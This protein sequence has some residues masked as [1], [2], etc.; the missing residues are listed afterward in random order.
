MDL[1]IIYTAQKI[2]EINV[3]ITLIK[4]NEEK[5]LFKGIDTIKLK[6]IDQFNIRS[7]ICLEKIT[8]G[9]VRFVY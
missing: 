4:I 3:L 7:Q 8:S 5:C 9:Q 1:T 2:K 6:Q